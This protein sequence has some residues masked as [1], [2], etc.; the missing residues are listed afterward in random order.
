MVAARSP[1]T[2]YNMHLGGQASRD[3]ADC[4]RLVWA[5]NAN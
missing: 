4:G 5:A 1:N 3:V 2:C